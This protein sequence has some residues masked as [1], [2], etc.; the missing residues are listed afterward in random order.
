MNTKA[1][2][3]KLGASCFF[4]FAVAMLFAPPHARA[5][6][7]LFTEGF[8]G[9]FPGASWTVGDSNASSGLVFW[10]D[11]NSAYGSIAARTGGW[12][13]YCAGI[14]NTVFN[15]T[16]TYSNNMLAYMSR[17]V[18]LAGFTGANVEFWYAIP[19]IETCCDRLTESRTR[20]PRSL[21]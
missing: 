4:L 20:T 21:P 3:G 18:N 15:P 12:K 8:E 14:S 5:Q 9:A 1:R 13:G 11:V 7:N 19:S 2:F 16:A 6:T 17:T 10:D